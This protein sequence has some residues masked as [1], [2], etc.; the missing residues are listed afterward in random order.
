MTKKE[1]ISQILELIFK[2]S[3]EPYKKNGKL[4]LDRFDAKNFILEFFDDYQL[5]KKKS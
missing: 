4:L 5:T 3:G 1:D 2:N